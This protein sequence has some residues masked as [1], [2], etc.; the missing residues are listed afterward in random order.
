MAGTLSKKT[1][2]HSSNFLSELKVTQAEGPNVSVK[3]TW[4]GRLGIAKARQNRKRALTAGGFG[5]TS[6]DVFEKRGKWLLV[7][8]VA[9]QVPKEAC[10][11][12]TINSSPE[13]RTDSWNRS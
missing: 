9:L 8:H 13:D 4:D 12:T 5:L 3:V 1:G 7:S 11:N 2:K 6:W 10:F